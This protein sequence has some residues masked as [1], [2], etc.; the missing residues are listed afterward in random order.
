MAQPTLSYNQSDEYTK[1]KKKL[2]ELLPTGPMNDPYLT[3]IGGQYD[4]VVND[5]NYSAYTQEQLDQM[6][7]TRKSKLM[8][9]WKG[10]EDRFAVRL[11]QRGL[12]GT[13]YG[14]KEWR[15][16]IATPENKA[17]ADMYNDIQNQNIEAT[18]SDKMSFMNMAPTLSNMYRSNQ[19]YPLEAYGQYLSML[20]PAEQRQFQQNLAQYEAEL[21]KYNTDKQE[22]TQKDASRN[23]IIGTVLGGLLGFL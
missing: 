16:D 22:R 14:N 7:N 9:E 5:P 17:L 19:S 23:N 8:D 11:G 3:S 4:K 13:T 15:E 2:S 1:T 10:N 21:S 18:R 6:Y 20:E 12:A